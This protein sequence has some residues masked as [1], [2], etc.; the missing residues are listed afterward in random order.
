[1]KNF[2]EMANSYI[3]NMSVKDMVLVKVCAWTMGFL[4]GIGLPQKH[5][6]KASYVASGIFVVTYLVVTLPFL[7]E[8]TDKMEESC[9]G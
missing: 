8:I 9:K 4:F 7:I 2:I 6:E 3:K 1:M 5:K